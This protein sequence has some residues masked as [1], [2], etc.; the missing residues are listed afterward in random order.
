[1]E[2]ID[3]ILADATVIPEGEK[4]FYS[5]KTVWL[6][7]SYQANDSKREIAADGPSRAAAGLP[8]DAFVFCNFNQ[9]YK[10]TPGM[11]AAWMRIL[12]RLDGSVL[13]LWQ[14]KDV[15]TANLRRAAEA[16]GVAGARLVFAE[17]LPPAR[18]LA[19][20]RLADLFLDSLPYNAHTTASDALWAGLP[21]LTC[22]G[23]TFP[24]RVA[25][26]LLQAAGLPELIAESL[27][28]YE[29]LAVALAREPA[30]LKGLRDRLAQNRLA[31]PLFD[32]ARFTRNLEAAYTRMWDINRRGEAPYSF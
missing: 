21:L 23:T 6:P 15:A 29:S 2:Y 32:T 26:S 11:F 30:R 22:R 19:R 5:E 31:S 8:A 1:M 14:S 20:L 18:H 27:P 17:A 24:G 4:Q 3:Y 28:D 9:S 13:W 16:Q 12:S 25:A 10:L 7:D